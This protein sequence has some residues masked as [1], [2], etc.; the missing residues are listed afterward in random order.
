[1][2]RSSS[3]RASLKIHLRFFYPPS[4]CKSC[5]IFI[6]SL[7][8][9][10]LNRISINS[11]FELPTRLFVEMIFGSCDSSPRASTSALGRSGNLA[12]T[13]RVVRSFADAPSDR[14]HT[15]TDKRTRSHVSP[16][17]RYVLHTRGE[18][19]LSGRSSY[20]R[21]FVYMPGPGERGPS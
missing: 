2:H 16:V 21:V 1:M 18:L 17:S 11:S 4:P 6:R 13:C 8:E 20:T 10:T 14:I 5:E 3:L 15:R 19:A 12:F 7:A 9:F